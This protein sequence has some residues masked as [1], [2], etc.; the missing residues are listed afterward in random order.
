LQ[1]GLD[2]DALALAAKLAG[3]PKRAR[4][5]YLQFH[6]TA[7]RLPDPTDRAAY[8]LLK[9]LKEDEQP[10]SGLPALPKFQTWAKYLRQA[11]APLGE[12]KHKRRLKPAPAD[13]RS[14]VPVG[15]RT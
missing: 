3:L 7:Q 15:E 6:C 4:V 10:E 9:L 12:Q 13:V 2:A 14:A 1:C 11:R 5:A 8:D